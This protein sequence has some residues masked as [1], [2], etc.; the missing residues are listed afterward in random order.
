MR[1]RLRS[2]LAMAPSEAGLTLVEL[3]VAASMSVLIVGAATSMLISAVQD[4]PDISERA[5]SVSSARWV[6]ERMTREIRSGVRVDEANATTVSFVGKVRRAE[7]GTSEALES[8]QPARECQIVYD[9]S[10]GAACTLAE[11]EKGE[12]PVSSITLIDGLGSAAVFNYSPSAEEPTYV[13]I[14]LNVPNPDGGALTVSDG[15][16]LRTPTLLSAG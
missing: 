9:C 3:L 12:A 16:S 11:A 2:R 14:T 7:C 5:Q 6:L 1:R 4:Q 13:G 10:S 15:A 8:G